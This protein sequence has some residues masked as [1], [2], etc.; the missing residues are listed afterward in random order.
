M[1]YR[2]LLLQNLD[3]DA[4]DR[5]QLRRIRL[6]ARF[7]MQ[8][9]RQPIAS[10]YFIEDGLGSITTLLENSVQIEVGQFAYESAVGIS[11]LFGRGPSPHR[12][13]MQI[14]GE[15]YM[16]SLERAKYEFVHN[17]QFSEMVLCCSQIHMAQATQAAAC[18]A[19]H[20]L[21]HR[22][23]RWLLLCSDRTGQ[24]EF[25]ISQDFVAGILG[26]SRSAISLCISALERRGL[27]THRRERVGIPNVP[28]LEEAA[29]ECYRV[30]QRHF[31]LEAPD[32]SQAVRADSSRASATLL[33]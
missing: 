33:R 13:V 32:R 2:N 10:L 22:L 6:P 7:Q 9:P 8:S 23:T 19:A 4:R 14:G 21:E 18:N 24:T 17:R 27:L 15:G 28:A 20:S 25:P 11:A 3:S 31:R 1:H 29:C 30:M 26:S 12:I 16:A 5:L